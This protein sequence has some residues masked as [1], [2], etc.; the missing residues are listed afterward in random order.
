MYLYDHQNQCLECKNETQCKDSYL[1]EIEKNVKNVLHKRDFDEI[2]QIINLLN[3]ISE[4]RNSNEFAINPNEFAQ[5]FSIEKTKINR[6]LKH[7]FPKVKRWTN[8]T[9]FVS[10]PVALG[11]LVTGNPFLAISGGMI[12]GV[13]KGSEE[14]I[15]YFE[16]K[17][18][19]IN[20]LNR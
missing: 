10:I 3:R 7:V 20:Y 9:T 19:W 2:Q 14:L 4:K 11:G 17:Y 1:L 6:K 5:E 15:K 8:L 18:N 12:T 13:A 16:N